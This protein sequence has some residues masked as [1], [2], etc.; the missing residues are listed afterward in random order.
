VAEKMRQTGKDFNAKAKS[1]LATDE[2][3][4]LNTESPP[5]QT[6]KSFRKPKTLRAK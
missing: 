5:P 2:T 4:M 1:F 3:Q 6:E